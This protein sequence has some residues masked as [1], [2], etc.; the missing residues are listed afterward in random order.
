M[1]AYHAD[2]LRKEDNIAGLSA[3]KP[4]PFRLPL[5]LKGFPLDS[6]QAVCSA[7]MPQRWDVKLPAS[8]LNTIQLL[9]LG[10]EQQI[11]FLKPFWQS[12]KINQVTL[13]TS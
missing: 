7:N 9:Q 4:T 5:A 8:M 1:S 10:L 13:V 2:F 12:S 3:Q 6:L 11:L